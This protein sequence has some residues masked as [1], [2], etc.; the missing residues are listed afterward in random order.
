MHA[1]IREAECIGCLKCIQA[2]PVDAILGA[3]KFMHTVITDECIGCEQCVAPCPVD[4][5][6]ML[7]GELNILSD[8][9]IEHAAARYAAR[10]ERLAFDKKAE[11]AHYERI[12]NGFVDNATEEEAKAAR[13]ALIEEIMKKRR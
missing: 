8:K 7:P 10:E 1:H 4:C 12:K 6:D 2:C 11:Q 5:I 9:K 13:K 3:A